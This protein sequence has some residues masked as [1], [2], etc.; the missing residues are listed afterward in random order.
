M[1]KISEHFTTEEF[2][3]RDG[4]GQC[5]IEPELVEQLEMIR[6]FFDKPVILYPDHCVNRCKEHNEKIGGVKNSQHLKGMAADFHVQGVGMNTLHLDM[7]KLYN[8]GKIRN[9]GLYGWGCHIDIRK[10]KHIWD[11]K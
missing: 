10:D 9:L 5:I 4:C 6:N 7:I 2:E 3:C 11:E 1:S 8:E